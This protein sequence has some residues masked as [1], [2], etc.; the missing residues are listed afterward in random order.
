LEKFS[1]NLGSVSSTLSASFL[2]YCVIIILFAFV[3]FS[4]L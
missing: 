3:A 1:L 4:G 2:P